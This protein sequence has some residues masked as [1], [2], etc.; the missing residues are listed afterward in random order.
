MPY[1]PLKHQKLML[2][3]RNGQAKARPEAYRHISDSERGEILKI[4][5]RMSYLH[6][7]RSHVP[8]RNPLHEGAGK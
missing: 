2:L 4:L 3:R 5:L 7:P 6:H 8:R 1:I